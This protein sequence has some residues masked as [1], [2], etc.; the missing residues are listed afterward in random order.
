MIIY[1]TTRKKYN[2]FLFGLDGKTYHSN[3]EHVM[4]I[5]FVNTPSFPVLALISDFDLN[6]NFK[7]SHSITQ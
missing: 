4:Y 6:L 5:I 3:F 7:I 2:M 1:I